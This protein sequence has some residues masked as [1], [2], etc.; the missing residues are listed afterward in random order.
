MRRWGYTTTDTQR[1]F[2]ATCHITQTRS[3]HDVTRHADQEH[4]VSWITGV[5]SLSSL[6][7]DCGCNVKTLERHFTPFWKEVVPPP[8]PGHIDHLVVDA[9]YAH[10]KET[11]VLV[12]RSQTG[13]WWRFTDRECTDTW[14]D[15]LK[16]FS[17]P[18][19]VTADGLHGIKKA[20]I[21]AFGADTPFQRCQ[22]HVIA[23]VRQYLCGIRG[24]RL[25]SQLREYVY[26]MHTVRTLEDRDRWMLLFELWCREYK[27]TTPLHDTHIDKARNTVRRAL[28]HLFTYI[29]CPGLPNTTNFVEGGV[30]AKID[31]VL[32]RHRGLS[33]TKQRVLISVV[34]S[35]LGGWVPST[36]KK[37][38]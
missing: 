12:A 6:A 15:F 26:G 35:C 25:A 36:N 37:D 8:I 3:R 38:P 19:G 28:P 29:T 16:N 17:S 18:V 10:G 24:N 22:F 9:T 2:C 13:L 5:R 11:C 21:L 31:E 33:T 7:E 23:Q 30:N 27:H 20:V 14:H 1:W 34:L 4:F 32:H